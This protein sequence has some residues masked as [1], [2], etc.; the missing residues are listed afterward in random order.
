MLEIAA[1]VIADG[2]VYNFR[3]ERQLSPLSGCT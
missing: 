3:D 1:A 2:P